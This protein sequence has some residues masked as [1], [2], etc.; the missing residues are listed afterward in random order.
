MLFLGVFDGCVWC[1]IFVFCE[2]IVFVQIGVNRLIK[3]VLLWLLFAD[4]ARKG[5]S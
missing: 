5:L 2:M 1:F 3:D 4:T